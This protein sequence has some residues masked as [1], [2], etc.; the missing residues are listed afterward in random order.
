[1]FD[2]SRRAKLD[3]QRYGQGGMKCF[4]QSIERIEIDAVIAAR[5]DG[6]PLLGIWGEDLDLV[7]ANPYAWT[8]VQ[9]GMVIAAAQVDQQERRRPVPL[10]LPAV[11]LVRFA[12]GEQLERCR[13]R[14][15]LDDREGIA[16]CFG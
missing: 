8:G 16:D 12:A 1:M 15:A 4:G 5:S 14:V 6:F 3:V 10:D 13:P 9:V 7:Q 2:A 11:G